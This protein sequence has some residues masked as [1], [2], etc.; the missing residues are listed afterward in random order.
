MHDVTHNDAHGAGLSEQGGDDAETTHTARGN[1]KLNEIYRVPEDPAVY[2]EQNT[3]LLPRLFSSTFPESQLATFRPS[4]MGS[5][6]G[7]S[8]NTMT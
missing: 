3:M 7:P 1:N 8:T 5:V 2:V 4:D 6:L